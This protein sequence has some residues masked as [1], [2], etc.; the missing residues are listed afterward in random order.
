M[1][2]YLETPM[3]SIF[4]YDVVELDPKG[5]ELVVL[6]QSLLPHQEKF[7]HIT[8]PEQLFYAITL[9]K[10]RGASAVAVAAALCT[11][12]CMNRYRTKSVAM[13]EKEFLRV[14]RYLSISRPTAIALAKA[15]ERMELRFYK[16]RSENY[17]DSKSA[18]RAIKAALTEEARAIKA[19]DIRLSLAIAENGLS[20]MSQGMGV[21]THG[22]PGHLSTSR[23]GTALGSIYVAQQKGLAPNVYVCETRPQLLGARLTTFELTKAG[24]E[25]TLVC[26]D[27]VPVLMSQRMV[28]AVF[29]G[30][31]RVVA[32]GDVVSDCGLL[33]LAIAARHYK[34]PVYCFTSSLSIDFVTTAGKYVKIPEGP[35]YEVTEMNFA[36]PSA[37]KGVKVFNPGL[38][39]TPAHLI[40]GIVTEK[41]IF[42]PSELNLLKE[43][44]G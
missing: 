22:N 30:C 44:N 11:A 18:V 4:P 34:I 20:L 15:L 29:A 8:A 9:L 43:N 1:K 3:E 21:V 39:V 19:E 5:K 31:D 36:S 14:K 24:V 7:I 17:P 28:S 41:G 2:K 27:A 12:M 25:T 32:N 37:A 35:S 16:A 26:D 6:D 38:D 40:T 23:Y 33:S 10:V 13:L 42:K